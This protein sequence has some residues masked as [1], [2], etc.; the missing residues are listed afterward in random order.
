MRWGIA[1][2][3][4]LLLAGCEAGEG[5]EPPRAEHSIDPL[6]GETRMTI[7]QGRRTATLLAGP[8]VPVALPDGL[9]LFPGTRVRNNARFARGDGEGS[10]VTFAADAPA[11]EIVAHYRREAEAAGFAVTLEHGAA[12]SVLLIAERSRDGARLAVSATGGTPTT[13]QLALSTIPRG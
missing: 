9:T 5:G 6:T 8:G 1:G 7:P 11:G 12:G 13:G 4:G 10:L 3:A 2:V